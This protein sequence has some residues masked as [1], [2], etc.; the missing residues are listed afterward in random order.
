MKELPYWM[1]AITSSVLMASNAFAE[2]ERPIDL[3]PKEV[4]ERVAIAALAPDDAVPEL[5]IRSSSAGLERDR[6]GAAPATQ[7]RMAIPQPGRG[8][9]SDLLEPAP[10]EQERLALPGDNLDVD[11]GWLG[12]WR[13]DRHY[14]EG[15]PPRFSA[16]DTTP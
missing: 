7:K 14:P 15:S 3:F 9:D 5:D 10:S 13:W 12:T 6:H 2:Q 11:L 16:S 1:A 4:I 8:I